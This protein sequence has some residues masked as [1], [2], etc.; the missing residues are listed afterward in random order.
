[1]KLS[2]KVRQIPQCLVAI[3]ILGM[4][5]LSIIAPATAFAASVATHKCAPTD[6]QCIIAAGDQ[7]IAQ[8][9]AA[10]TTLSG[11]IRARQNEDLITSD[12]ANALQSD[13]GTNQ[14]GLASLK[15]RL[16]AEK[17]AQAARQDVQNIF[18]Q[19]RI[20]AVVLPRDYR[21][22][23][24]DVALNVDIKLRNLGPKVQQAI[25]NA[26]PGEKAQLNTLFNDYKHQLATA[27]S[28]FDS[29]QAD[30]PAL[31]PANYNYNRATYVATLTK[32]DNALH[33]IHAALH[34]ARNDIH[35]IAKILKGNK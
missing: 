12:Q 26:P 24:L 34:Q 30:F 15:S 23:Y 33:I 29:A 1:M 6:T 16:D 3:G 21:R 14:S 35:Q 5:A 4:M 32:L 20:F 8:R 7:F 9:Q 19:F 25:D 11:K 27:E 10:L 22:L 2:G 18:L 17:N 31:T 28:Q 13:V